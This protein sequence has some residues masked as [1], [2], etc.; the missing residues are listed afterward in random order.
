MKHGLK[1][2]MTTMQYYSMILATFL[3][4]SQSKLLGFHRHFSLSL[5]I[6]NDTH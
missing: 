2:T 6:A 3:C 1:N 5:Y 4:L